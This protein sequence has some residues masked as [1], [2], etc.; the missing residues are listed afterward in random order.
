MSSL[1]DELRAVVRGEVD[2]SQAARDACSRDASLFRV[3][4]EVVVR[5]QDA[6][7]ICALVDFVN[8][9]KKI[10]KTHLSVTAR[11]AGTDMGGGPLGDSIVLDITAHVNRLIE[12]GEDYAVVEPGMYFRDFDKETAKK[13]LELPSYKIG[14]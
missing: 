4:P 13:N 10:P 2:D 1:S 7:D 5:P 11:A 12:L 3:E 14:R 9:K 6:Q 8:E